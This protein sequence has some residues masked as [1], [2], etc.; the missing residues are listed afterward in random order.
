MSNKAEQAYEEYCKQDHGAYVD[1]KI[2]FLSGWN[3]GI[4][5]AMDIVFTNK[6]EVNNEEASWF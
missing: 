4:E 5:A 1:E 6:K 3:A 2:A